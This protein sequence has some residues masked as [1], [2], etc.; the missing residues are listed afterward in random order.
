M[1]ESEAE[2]RSRLCC[3][4]VHRQNVPVWYSSGEERVLV[5]IN[6]GKI[7]AELVWV[8]ATGSGVVLLVVMAFE[9]AWE[10]DADLAR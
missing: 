3:Y 1:R 4:S 7:R 9:V 5:S 6:R 8:T 2:V 10:A